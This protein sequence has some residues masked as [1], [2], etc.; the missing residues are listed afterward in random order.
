M[1]VIA[2]EVGGRR[3]KAPKGRRTRPTADRIRE[4]LFSTIAPWLPGAQVLDLYAG[5]GAV[6]IE[7]LS[8]GASSAVFVESDPQ[9]VRVIREN[10]ATLGLA[11]HAR[12]IHSDALRAIPGLIRMGDRFRLIF[13]DPPYRI[14]VEPVLAR[15]ASARLVE[16]GGLVIVQHFSKTALPPLSDLTLWKT[17]RYGETTLTFLRVRE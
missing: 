7:A 13:L 2:G 16:R 17:K 5:S 10:L 11:D 14:S 15:V 9:A 4:A 12:L 3:I 1:R 8:R 6:G